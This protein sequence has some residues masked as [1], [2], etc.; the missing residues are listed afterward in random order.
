LIRC[1]QSEKEGRKTNLPV[2]NQNVSEQRVKKK[3][4][5]AIRRCHVSKGIC[6][7]KRKK[8]CDSSS[9][10]AEKKR[11]NSARSIDLP[12][13]HGKK[14]KGVALDNVLNPFEKKERIRGRRVSFFEHRK[15]RYPTS[16]KLVGKKR[17]E[18]RETAEG[19]FR[20]FHSFKGRLKGKE[21]K[22][23][24]FVLYDRDRKKTGA[25]VNGNEKRKR[26]KAAPR[27]EYAVQPLARKEKEERKRWPLRPPRIPVHLGI[28]PRKEGRKRKRKSCRRIPEGQFEK[29][30]GDALRAAIVHRQLRKEKKGSRISVQRT[31]EWRKAFVG[32]LSSS[33]EK[34]KGP[35]P[36]T[37]WKKKRFPLDVL[38]E[39]KGIFS[40]RGRAGKRKREDPD[41]FS[42]PRRKRKREGPSRVELPYRRGGRESDDYGRHLPVDIE[43]AGGK[44]EES[45]LKT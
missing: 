37:R 36:R 19:A 13:G 40:L 15:G 43:R 16:L 26:K 5:D 33:K 23:R 11:K 9:D 29:K 22:S 3:E 30:K 41:P 28:E 35:M 24:R 45:P 27:V 12:E 21:K 10:H 1:P 7:G 20:Q 18:R 8:R 38:G 34:E 14:E 39:K 6:T 17:K 31:S 42:A 4:R 44:K 25:L 32:F 2:R